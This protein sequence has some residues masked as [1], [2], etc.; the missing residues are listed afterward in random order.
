MRQKLKV[1]SNL[2]KLKITVIERFELSVHMF[3]FVS[4]QFN[5]ESEKSVK[6]LNLENPLN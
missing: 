5:F 4:F 3:K 6:F 1:F 2:K